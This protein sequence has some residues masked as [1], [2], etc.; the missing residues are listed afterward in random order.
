MSETPEQRAR[1]Q[2]DAML[3]ASGCA[4]QAKE[5]INLS[6]CRGMA[7]C[8]LSFS[9]GEPDYTL[10][11]D[12]KAIGTAEAKPE[13]FPLSGVEE[14][15]AKYATGFPGG[16]PAWRKPLPFCCESTSSE[17]RFTNRLDPD[18]RSRNIFTFHRPETLLAYLVVEVERRLSVSEELESVVSA[19]LLRAVRLR[20]S[21]LQK[22]FSGES[23]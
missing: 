15:S 14:E 2:I 19:N 3:A 18:P 5:R 16:L 9:T 21:I 10:F 4:V 13:S 7:V 11:A 12:G 8:E 1:H 6:A 22:A 17:T 23:M 20:Q